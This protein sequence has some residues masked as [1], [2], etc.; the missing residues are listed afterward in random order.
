MLSSGEWVSF[1]LPMLNGNKIEIRQLN[2]WPDVI[3]GFDHRGEILVND[4]RDNSQKSD[5]LFL[6]HENASWSLPW[7]CHW[8]MEDTKE[9][10]H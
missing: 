4:L 5:A 9:W 10:L 2:R 3:V 8:L 6:L 7:I 1:L